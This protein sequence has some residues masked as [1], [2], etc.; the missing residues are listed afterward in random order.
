MDIFIPQWVKSSF[1]A[2]K[3]R[4]IA[5]SPFKEIEEHMR[6]IL[7]IAPACRLTVNDIIEMFKIISEEE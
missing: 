3:H 6:K 7:K 2:E 1:V 5:G 4:N